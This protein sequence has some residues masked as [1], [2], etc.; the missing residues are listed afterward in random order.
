M[1]FW[2]GTPGSAAANSG[3]T[4]YCHDADQGNQTI[5]ID[6]DRSD[7]VPASSFDVD[8][9]SNGDGSADYAV[10]SG[11]ASIEFTT[12]SHSSHVLTVT[13]PPGE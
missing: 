11:P 8:L 1:S 10:P 13:Y 3:I 7:S 4:V 5:T 2:N 12:E 9:D 6:V